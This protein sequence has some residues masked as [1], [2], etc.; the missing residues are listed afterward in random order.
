M[1]LVLVMENV[2]GEQKVKCFYERG[3]IIVFVCAHA[4]QEC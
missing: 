4:E 3:I 1:E 2:L